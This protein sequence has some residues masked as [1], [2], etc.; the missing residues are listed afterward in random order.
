MLKARVIE[1]NEGIQSE[2]TAGMFDLF[3]RGMRDKGWNNVDSMTASGI[4]GGD[5]LEI[6]PGPG[7]VGLELYKKVRPRSLT[8]CE[9]SQAMIDIARKNAKEYGISACYQTGNAMQMPFEDE[10][11]DH[12]ISNGSMHEWESPIRVFNEIFRV[13]RPGGRYY[14]SDLRR[15]I[16]P[17]KKMLVYGSTK[18]REMRGGLIS[19]LNASYTAFEIK[20]LV[21]NSKLCSATVTEDFFGLSISGVK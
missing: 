10:S 18:P 4:N 17:I 12:V 16:S 13:L 2:V 20:E 21:R 3:A 5:V 14:I 19:S 7:Y 11:F 15:N 8:G 1:T 9:I 6:G